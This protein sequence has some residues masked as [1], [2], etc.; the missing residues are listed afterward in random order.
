VEKVQGWL[1][2]KLS[3][4]AK[5]T[6][7]IGSVDGGLTEI[8]DGDVDVF[9]CTIIDVLTRQILSEYGVYAQENSLSQ[10]RHPLQFSS[11][12]VAKG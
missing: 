7:S 6:F 3:A 11:F 10:T 8:A 1:R 4:L 9:P 12:C 5:K 2:A